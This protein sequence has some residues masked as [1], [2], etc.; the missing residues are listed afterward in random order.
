MPADWW[1][2]TISLA[3]EFRSQLSTANILS[4]IIRLLGAAAPKRR[5]TLAYYAAGVVTLCGSCLVPLAPVRAQSDI[6]HS[7]LAAVLEAHW[8]LSDKEAAALERGDVLA[9]ALPS[10]DR[11]DVALVGLTVVNVPR[12][13]YTAVAQDVNSTLLAPY[14]VAAEAFHDPAAVEDLSAMTLAESELKDLRKCRPQHCGMKLPARVM[15][16]VRASMDGSASAVSHGT[17]AMRAWMASL[18]NEYRT[19]GDSALPVY[20]DTELAEHSVDGFRHL[21][22]QDSALLRHAPALTSALQRGPD[23]QPSDIPGVLYWATDARPGLS[24]VVSIFQLSTYSPPDRSDVSFV[25]TKQLYASHYFDAYLDATMLADRAGGGGSS[26][27]LTVRRV[28]FDRLPSGGL[29]D[30]RGRIVRRMRSGLRDEL[31][32]VREAIEAAYLHSAH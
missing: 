16:D 6:R 14:R 23:V 27:V 3:T 31:A 4:G 9:R 28:R 8:S 5:R 20:D 10:S 15:F 22:Q 11:N 12:S 18:V 32:K 1:Y 30:V 19:R 25:A 7:G 13:F 26:Y 17:D 24:T 2:V 29:F 21:L